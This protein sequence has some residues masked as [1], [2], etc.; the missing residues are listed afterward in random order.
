MFLKQTTLLASCVLL[1]FSTF[2]IAQECSYTMAS[3]DINSSTTWS[4]THS[5]TTDVH[6]RSGGTLTLTGTLEMLE[7]NRVVIHPGGKMIIDG[8]TATRT[9]TC[10]DTWMGI[11]VRGKSHLP[12]TPANQGVLEIKN[13][14]TISYASSGFGNATRNSNKFNWQETGGIIYANN[15][16]F[17]N[18]T[19]DAWFISYSSLDGN[20]QEK[21]YEATFTNCNF[22]RDNNFNSD[23]MLPQITMLE[24]TGVKFNGCEF[25]CTN[26]DA[27]WAHAIDAFFTVRATYTINQSS[28]RNS[29]FSGY[30]KAILSRD[31]A[32]PDKVISIKNTDFEENTYGVNLVGCAN[33]IFRN[34]QLNIPRRSSID[35]NDGYTI[36]SYGVF[37]DASY[38]FE[39][40]END[41]FYMDANGNIVAESGGNGLVVRDGGTQTNKVYKNTF[42]GLLTACSALN[43]NRNSDGT[44]GLIIQC[45]DFAQNFPDVWVFKSAFGQQSPS[46]E[47][48]IAKKQGIWD[49]TAQ[50][51][52]T[53]ANNLF[54]RNT[55]ANDWADYYIYHQCEPSDY[56]YS[57]DGIRNEPIHPHRL[58]LNGIFVNFNYDNFCPSPPT[59]AGLSE[60][61]LLNDLALA[62]ADFTQS[63]AQLSALLDG[64]NTAQLEAQILISSS[65]TDYQNLYIDLMNLSPYVSEENVLNLLSLPNF[66][67]MALRNI[68]VANPHSASSNAIKEAVYAYNPPLSTQTITDIENGSLSTTTKDVLEAKISQA[69]I[70][71]H[72][73]VSRLLHY[74]QHTGNDEDDITTLLDQRSEN[75]Y[76]YMMLDME[77]H[78]GDL[79]AATTRLQDLSTGTA[80]QERE[81]VLFDDYLEAYY[82]LQMDV[83]E[84]NRTLGELTENEI[85]QLQNLMDENTG[86]AQAKIQSLLW[87][88]NVSSHYYE[89]EGVS[90]TSQ[91]KA[92]DPRIRP[93]AAPSVIKLYPNPAH[94]YSILQWNWLSLGL[95][96]SM[97]VQVYNSNGQ[98]VQT[99]SIKDYQANTFV[100]DTKNW[101]MGLY[102]IE[103]KSG[104]VLLLNEKLII[105][106]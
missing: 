51:G 1:L 105:Q 106:H 42:E 74:Y 25:I 62:D 68:L 76:Q 43:N 94:A 101:Q 89:P 103:V 19:R 32:R 78:K 13:Q 37:L 65:Q 52:K 12:Q 36:Y 46:N 29:L 21:D 61:P 53:L 9:A 59:V 10:F 97:E 35:P 27:T 58:S 8:G 98:V 26:T 14:G 18:N 24:V 85:S 31:A 102:F 87:Q 57:N 77:I 3:I 93:D 33:F 71:R 48:G 91:K 64:G 6:I 30:R 55:K 45:N 75:H 72:T 69:N 90:T 84:D 80:L 39:I 47:I 70:D 7:L 38:N 11:E 23:V 2:S 22:I 34:N 92:S 41:F 100:L 54:S 88:N 4:G 40:T 95:R 63:S 79:S 44:D 81:R 20:N 73:A 15:A 82:Q 66:P 99:Y 16:N 50:D 17:I 56:T 5:L 86:M 104:E 49:F 28:S 96:Q 60:T 67:E 83:L